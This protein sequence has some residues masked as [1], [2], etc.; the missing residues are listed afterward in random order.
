MKKNTFETAL[1]S[2]IGVI[3]LLG[4]LVAFNVVTAAFKTRVDL[5]RRR[6]TP[7]PPA[8]GP[9]CKNWMLR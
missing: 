4:V 9:S 3:V 8:R 6:C 1:Y 7:F 5:T 2:V